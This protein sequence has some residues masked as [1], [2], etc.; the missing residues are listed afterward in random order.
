MAISGCCHG[1]DSVSSRFVRSGW[2]TD[3]ESGFGLMR[4]DHD[5]FAVA[6]ILQDSTVSE[7]DLEIGDL[8]EQIKVLGLTVTQRPTPGLIRR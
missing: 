8:V 5:G 2:P 6:L 1:P 4:T 3:A 7:A